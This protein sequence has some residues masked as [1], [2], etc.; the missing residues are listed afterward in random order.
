MSQLQSETRL[1]LVQ[2]MVINMIFKRN[3]ETHDETMQ[4]LQRKKRIAEMKY[5]ERKMKYEIIRLYFPFRLAIKFNKLIVTFCIVAIISYTI[6][7]ILLQKYTSM[8]L[9]PTL[10]TCVFAFFGT[11]LLGLASIKICD[12]KFTIQDSAT[13]SSSIYDEDAVG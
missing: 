3:Y 5:E 12:T 8:E 10:T 7:A 13:S 2:K 11:E 6:A 4:R 9:S 1:V